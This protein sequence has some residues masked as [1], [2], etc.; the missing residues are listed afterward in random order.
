[1]LAHRAQADERQ[2]FPVGVKVKN[3]RGIWLAF[4]LGI[5][6]LGLT[7]L[8]PL[9]LL[10]LGPLLLGVPHLLAGLRYLAVR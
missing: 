9:W 6:A 5:A 1:M 4:G 2:R 8:A 7:R 3:E 10:A